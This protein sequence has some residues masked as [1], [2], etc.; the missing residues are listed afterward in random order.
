MCFKEIELIFIQYLT[1]I[2]RQNSTILKSSCIKY[3]NTAQK[4]LIRVFIAGKQA[5]RRLFEVKNTAVSTTGRFFGL[6]FQ[7]GGY[8]N[9]KLQKVPTLYPFCKFNLRWI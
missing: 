3:Y 7:I 9:C 2:L 8:G 1:V 5:I 4:N 6:N